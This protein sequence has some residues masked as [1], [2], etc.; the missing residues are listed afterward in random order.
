MGLMAHIVVVKVIGVFII[1][2]I[3]T[4]MKNV[5]INV[6]IRVINHEATAHV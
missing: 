3:H 2:E 6:M 1:N 4:V 5:V